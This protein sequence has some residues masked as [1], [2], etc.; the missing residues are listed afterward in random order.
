MKIRMTLT[1]LL[2]IAFS[3]VLSAANKKSKIYIYGFSASF[4]DSTVYFT[5]I[6][7]LDSAWTDQ[8]T[9]FLYSRDNYSYQLR[10]YLKTQGVDHPTCITSYGLKRKD[11]EKKYT[12]LRKKYTTGGQYT[13]RYITA[14]EFQF[15]PIEPD[16]SDKVSEK[17]L[18][19]AEKK[20]AQKAEKEQKAREKAERKAAGKPDM[21]KGSMPPPPGGEGGARPPMNP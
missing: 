16:D 4:N 12:R 9:D 3:T 11:A 13:V 19:K 17:K 1:I 18:S 7:E 5:E 2:L 10:D 20:S 6:Q 15:S 14:N 21:K 8:K